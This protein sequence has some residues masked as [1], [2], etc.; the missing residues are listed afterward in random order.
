MGNLSIEYLALDAALKQ[1]GQHLIM[2][3]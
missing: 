2:V 1:Q 3:F